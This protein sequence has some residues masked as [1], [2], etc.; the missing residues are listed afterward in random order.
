MFNK[1]YLIT[2]MP[3]QGRKVHAVAA[4]RRAVLVNGRVHSVSSGVGRVAHRK[5]CALAHDIAKKEH[6]HDLLEQGIEE[7]TVQFRVVGG[8]IMN[9]PDYE[10]HHIAMPDVEDED[11][12][13]QA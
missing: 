2:Y 9:P 1:P 11:E 13:K 12:E 10:A 5:I 3:K 6:R 8:R 4:M 7:M